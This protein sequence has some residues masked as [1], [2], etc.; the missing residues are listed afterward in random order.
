MKRLTR[1][2][3][4]LACAALILLGSGCQGR[5][6][7]NR[8]YDARD[9]FALGAGITAEPDGVASKFITPSPLSLGLYIEASDWFHLGAITHNGYTA[10]ADLRGTFVGPESTTRYG[11]LWWQMLRKYEDY[12]N[13][14]YMNP[15]K[16][17]SFIWCQRM[18]SISMRTKRRPAKRLHYEHWALHRQEGTAL[19][20]RG[21]Q[22]WEY[23]G[24]EGAISDPFFTHLGVMLKFG[25]DMSEV[26]DYLLG[27]F[28]VDY[29][30]DDMNEEEYEIF[31]AMRDGHYASSTPQATPAAPE[32]APAPAPE[33]EAT[34]APEPPKPPEDLTEGVG[35]TTATDE[36]IEI[37]FPEAVFFDSGSNIIK[38]E[39]CQIL[40]AL[41]GRIKNGYPDYEI[42]VVGHT[43]S[44]PIGKS[45]KQW[46]SN[47]DLGAGRAIAVV[48]YLINEQKL[49]K[50]SFAAMTYA[51]NKPVG[52]N[53]TLEGRKQNRRTVLL[54]KKP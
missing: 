1:L 13:A 5:F 42:I 2:A 4:A 6:M 15:F 41:A 12:E 25:F 43:D 16:D 8:Y 26:S 18:E 35:T 39:G 20:H 33:P 21:K 9:T 48:E 45:K 27:W 29:K 40:E 47:W 10:E 34:P 52:D 30:H 51:D 24:I 17:K 31:R 7:T 3:P 53:A 22:Y 36:G 38:P 46:D 14:H 11:F 44:M 37:I 49:E 23:A 19:L 54:L 50:T 28:G 32:P